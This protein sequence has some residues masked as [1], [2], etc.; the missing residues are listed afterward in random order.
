MRL[1][2]NGTE[3]GKGRIS[4]P[5]RTV[6]LA[7]GIGRGPAFNYSLP[8]FDPDVLSKYPIQGYNLYPNLGGA[9][10]GAGVGITPNLASQGIYDFSLFASNGVGAPSNIG[11]FFYDTD[12]PTIYNDLNA[13]K[14]FHISQFR[15]DL[16]RLRFDTKAWPNVNFA[17]SKVNLTQN[18]EGISYLTFRN[19]RNERNEISPFYYV[20]PEYANKPLAAQNTVV[21]YTDLI[22]DRNCKIYLDMP[23][24]TDLSV[25][26]SFQVS[27]YELV[28]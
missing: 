16:Y 4:G 12:L 28:K 19:F 3:F 18:I 8:L 22:M 15:I 5:S 13:G 10:Q 7:T 20:T 9:G 25:I 27:S 2:S 24:I 6:Q 11:G 21:V 1:F 14:L 26:V 23:A 17:S